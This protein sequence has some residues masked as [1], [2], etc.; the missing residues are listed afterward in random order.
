MGPARAQSVK[1]IAQEKWGAPF[2]LGCPLHGG[3]TR[4]KMDRMLNALRLLR[5]DLRQKARWSY[6]RDD[7]AA[8]AKVL[9]SDGTFAMV[10]YR[11]MQG[12]RESGLP[13]LEMI[14]NKVNTAF[15][16]CVIGRGAEFGPGFVL[17][18][19]N[20]VVINGKVRGGSG[21]HLHH[22]VTIGENEAGQSPVLGSNIEIGAGAKIIGGVKIGDGV[23]IGANAV[24]V[25]DVP[26]YT[27]AVGIPAKPVI[28]TAH[29]DAARREN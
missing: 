5:E 6:K 15:G 26:P 22:E 16:A 17:F 4:E 10:T 13:L 24:V 9:L 8:I 1:T 29:D 3:F 12:S 19:S 23:R 27:T 18:H 25:H 14:F 11:L 21:I 28:R 20:C 7:F 2:R